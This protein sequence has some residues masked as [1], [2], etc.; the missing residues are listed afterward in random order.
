M[1]ILITLA[2]SQLHAQVI[3]SIKSPTYIKNITK[4]SRAYP[5]INYDIN[6]LEWTNADALEPFFAKL[7]T[8]G[9]RKVKVLHIG[10]SH[11]QADF[12]PGYIRENIQAVF[13]YGGRGFVFPYACAN[14]HATYDYKT[15]DYGLWECAKNIQ[16][17]PALELGIS[18][19]TSRTTDPAAGFKFIFFRQN[20]IRKEFDQIKIYCKQGPESFDLKMKCSGSPDTIRIDCNK[21]TKSAFITVKIP[22]IGDTIQFWVD[23]NDSSQ[24]Y[25]ECQGILIE[26]SANAGI[27]YNSVGINGAG[28]TSILRQSLFPFQ[29]TELSPDLVI[30]DVGA[31]DFY[32][33]PIVGPEFQN[34]LA[35]VIEMVRQ[36]SPKSSILISCSQDIYKRSRNIAGTK[37]FSDIARSVAFQK[38]CAFYDWFHISGGQYSMLK[39]L[40]SKLAKPDK[41][42]LTTEGYNVKG[43]LYLNAILNTYYQFLNGGLPDTFLVKNGVPALE[44]KLDPTPRDTT[45]KYKPPVDTV[46][47]VIQ[48]KLIVHKIKSGETIGGIA[49]KYGVTIVQIKAWN[50]LRGNTLIA[51]RTL[52]IYKKG[53]E[54]KTT[55]N[56]TQVKPN[57]NNAN[58]NTNNST[59][60]KNG[61]KTYIV[62]SGDSLWSISQKFGTT[63][64]KIK[65]ANGMNNN[66]I[67]PGTKLIIP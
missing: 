45:Q 36:A 15:Y 12:F 33:R 10:D 47:K 46:T 27:L 4:Y 6:Y 64:E 9:T 3:D 56:Q 63:V 25:F 48:P 41:V 54:I 8:A 19:V 18:G 40:K 5:F 21:S 31:N 37:Q 23:R 30:I 59:Q 51:G 17:N 52:K 22:A 61:S 7:S 49:M 2:V 24:K 14:T 20:I 42:H 16:A 13:G 66:N 60:P 39:W 65:K 11:I 1:V 34:N 53:A 35:G 55:P 57:N 67:Q 32:P 38:N 26:S 62:R 44:L 28:Y 58:N 29:L 43:E 50:N